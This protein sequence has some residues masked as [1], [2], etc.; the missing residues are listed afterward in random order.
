[1]TS[2]RCPERTVGCAYPARLFGKSRTGRL[3]GSLFSGLDCVEP[4]PA[5]REICNR[6]WAATLGCRG[7]VPGPPPPRPR[8]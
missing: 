6:C 3:P 5:S 7:L 1:M 2:A 4:V 8:R